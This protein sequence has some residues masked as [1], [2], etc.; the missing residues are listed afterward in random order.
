MP[1]FGLR[2]F[3]PSEQPT[4]DTVVRSSKNGNF[5]HS[6]D[7]LSYHADRFD[8]RSA[9]IL[10]DRKPV[11]VFPCTAD[12][13]QLVSHAGL[14]YG[15]L[16]Y[17]V[18]LRAS[19][20][21]QIMEVLI[22]NYRTF[23]FRKIIYKAI[24][25]IFHNYP[26]GEDLYAL[27]RCG[28]QLVRRDLSSAIPIPNRLKLSDSRKNTIRKAQKAGVIVHA[29]IEVGIF[30]SLLTRTL[31]ERHGVS[32]V[33][34]LRDL[35]FLRNLFPSRI[36]AFGAYRDGG[37]ELLAGALVYDF[38]NVVHSQYLASSD[39]GRA[40]GALDLLLEQLLSSFFADHQYFS[41][42]ISTERDGH[43]LNEG[44][45]FHMEGFGARGVVHDFYEIA[46]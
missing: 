7:Y 18:D 37:D 3:D 12:G 27:H 41:F 35:Q 24:P 45:V 22:G 21:L 2:P 13:V 19:D 32:P 9:V 38:G 40:V 30:H 23:G 8:E 46:L 20:V 26:T 31:L 42:G 4:W 10:K 17:G 16:I 36:R 33:H 14:T 39:E 44:L 5:L 29:D 43:F 6:R 11:A 1:E 25:Y 28:A 15:G 34:N